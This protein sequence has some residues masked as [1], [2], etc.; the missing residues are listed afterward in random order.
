MEQ[1]YQMIRMYRPRELD[2]GESEKPDGFSKVKID[3][4]RLNDNEYLKSLKEDSDTT[5]KDNQISLQEYTNDQL[6]NSDMFLFTKWVNP[7]LYAEFIGDK[8]Q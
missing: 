4:T 5:P 8:K 3:Q 1:E 2:R 6:Q 7:S